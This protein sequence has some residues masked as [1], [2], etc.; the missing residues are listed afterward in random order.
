MTKI[1]KLGINLAVATT[2]CFNGC[3]SS[4]EDLGNT[5]T[6]KFNTAVKLNLAD[7]N[8][9]DLIT[10]EGSGATNFR[11]KNKSSNN[12]D[13]TSLKLSNIVKNN[14][15]NLMYE[16]TTRSSREV[17]GDG[18]IRTVI[19]TNEGSI[20][21]TETIN[22]DFNM[23][24]GKFSGSMSFSNYKDVEDDECGVD[25]VTSMVGI[26]NVT[27]LIDIET[28]DIENMIISSNENFLLDD[29]IWKSGFSMTMEYNNDSLYEEEVLMTMTVEAYI[30][31]ESFGFKDY[32]INSYSYN[33][34]EY[35]YPVKGNIYLFTNELNGYFSVDSSYDHSLTPTKEDVCGEY[36]Y[37]GLE[38]YIGKDSSMTWQITSI[39]NY[40][41]EIDSNNNGTV[42][43]T[44][45]GIV[46]D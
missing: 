36:T 13:K 32:Q 23:L 27:G 35:E 14:I 9:Y 19:E 8:N 16:R 2:L 20:S 1:K 39:N 26:F 15:N 11:S 42:D 33:G 29:M 28:E 7:L 24:T 38:K 25:E 43:I 5:T 17:T 3:G 30:N 41:I 45:T 37:S 40:K 18:D 31:N 12:T 34:Y 46:G 4:D 10:G 21:G 22:I 44:K 6:S